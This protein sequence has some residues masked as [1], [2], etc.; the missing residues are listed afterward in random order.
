[1]SIFFLLKKVENHLKRQDKN[2]AFK[3]IKKIKKEYPKNKSLKDFI[4]QNKNR[5]SRK[6]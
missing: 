6:E 3:L 2:L 5:I 4:E 1:M